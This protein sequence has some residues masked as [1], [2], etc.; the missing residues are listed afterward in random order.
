M[1]EN[2]YTLALDERIAKIEESLDDDKALDIVTLDIGKQSN[3]AQ[4]MIVAVGESQRQLVAM[5]YHLKSLFKE[6]NETSSIEGLEVESGWIVLDGGDI[7]I[8]LLLPEKRELYS[9]EKIW[10]AAFDKGSVEVVEG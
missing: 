4:R 7:V 5:A 6:W 3:F 2:K 1:T 8:H 10:S 9:I